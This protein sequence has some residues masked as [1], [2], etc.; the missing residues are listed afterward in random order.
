[1]IEAGIEHTLLR[2]ENG[3]LLQQSHFQIA[4]ED[5]TTGVITLLAREDREQRRLT[6]TILGNQSHLL[7][8]SDGK[9]DILEK[10]QRT[11]RLGQVLYV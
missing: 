10:H 6:H 7:S 2:V 11:K 1:M 8:L 3:R 4:T 9:T 5:N